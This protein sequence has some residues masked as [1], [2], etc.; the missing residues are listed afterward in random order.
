MMR[1]GA[2]TGCCL[3]V[4]IT[5][6]IEALAQTSIRAIE[7][8]TPPRHFN[9]WDRE[10]VQALRHD[11]LKT[12]IAAIAIHAPFGGPLDL[13]DSSPQHR[14]TAVDAVLTA[15]A[16]LKELGGRIVVVHISDVTR[17]GDRDARLMTSAESLGTLHR[18]CAATGMTLA[19]ETPLPHL[20]GGSPEEF[21]RV[22]DIVGPQA[23][24]C[25]DTGHTAL[26]GHWDAFVAL[27]GERIAHV[28]AHDNHGRFDDH[29]PPGEGRLDWRHIADSLRRVAFTEWAMLELRCPGGAL[30]EYFARAA[31]RLRALTAA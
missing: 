22:L 13:S 21:L 18:A 29:L 5:A 6:V 8:G 19:I 28:H 26:G 11:L 12:G 30:A 7:I 9:L 23:R 4:P 25:L 1:I 2:S 20:V 14:S 16:V 24:V 15:A 10:Q 17:G 31:G 3:D 27:A